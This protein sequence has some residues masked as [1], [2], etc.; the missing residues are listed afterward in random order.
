MAITVLCAD[1]KCVQRDNCL[2]FTVDPASELAANKRVRI[3]QTLRG[4]LDQDCK[5]FK[6][7][8]IPKLREFA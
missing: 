6:S 4:K 5:K 3:E 2:R 8:N 7:I 1:G